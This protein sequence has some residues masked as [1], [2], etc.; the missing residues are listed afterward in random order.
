M[1]LAIS[2]DRASEESLE[3][4][5]EE[6]E[7]NARLPL[8]SI[9]RTSGMRRGRGRR[10]GDSVSLP[11]AGPKLPI[12]SGRSPLSRT[13]LD[14]PSAATRYAPDVSPK[15]PGAMVPSRQLADTYVLPLRALL[16][17]RHAEKPRWVRAPGNV[18]TIS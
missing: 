17:C 5:E 6:G 16:T 18:C 15:N 12:P 9:R 2:M 14:Q 7:A 1:R 3:E 4:E 10:G 8:I 11:T 13:A